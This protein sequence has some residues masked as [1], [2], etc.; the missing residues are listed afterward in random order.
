MSAAT[1]ELSVTKTFLSF[2]YKHMQ[3]NGDLPLAIVHQNVE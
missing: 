2:F 3:T 1:Y